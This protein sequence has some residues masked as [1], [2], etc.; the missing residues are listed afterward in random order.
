MNNAWYIKDITIKE[1]DDINDGNDSDTSE[2][3]NFED[4]SS[5]DYDFSDNFKNVGSHH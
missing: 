1:T 3:N 5:P 4:Y 2:S